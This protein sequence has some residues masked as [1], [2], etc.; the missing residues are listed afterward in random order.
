MKRLALGILFLVV[1]IL[2]FTTAH[3]AAVDIPADS[4]RLNARLSARIQPSVRSWITLE[5]NKLRG[6]SVV[7]ENRLRADIAARFKGQ[8]LGSNDIDAIAFLVIMQATRDADSDL[9]A[10]ME[11]VKATNESKRKTQEF[12]APLKS[13]QTPARQGSPAMMKGGP[14]GPV[15]AGTAPENTAQNLDSMNEMSEMNSLRMQMMMDRRSKFISTLSNIMKK[16]TTTQETL[17]QNLK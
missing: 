6:Q 3:A 2:P 7:D 10:T 15:K 17:V 11:K 4:E 12:A 5:A 1:S 16:I 13:A 9:K 14:A 8:N